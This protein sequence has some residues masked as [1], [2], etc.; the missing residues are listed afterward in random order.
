DILAAI[1]ACSKHLIDFGGH[2]MAAG[3]TIE[4]QRIDLFASEFEAYAQQYLSESDCAA[5]L[6]IDATAPLSGFRRET[7]SE[8]QMLEPFGPGNQRPIFATKGVR[9]AAP[10]R[11]VGSGG[12]HLQLTITDNAAAVRCIGFRFGKLEKKLLDHEFFD[13]A[14][15][16]QLN[17]YN[18]VSNVE[19]VLEDV[20]F[21]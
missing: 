3:M 4:P 1:S 8:L 9:L 18:G 19:F 14:Y 13:V 5:K 21:E 17:T 11:K 6:H 12:E 10:P 7:V 16:P 15:Q 20:Q 2:K